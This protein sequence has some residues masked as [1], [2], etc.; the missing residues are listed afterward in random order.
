MDQAAPGRRAQIGAY[1]RQRRLRLDGRPMGPAKDRR[2]VDHLTQADV[3]ELAGVS[4]ALVAQ[5]ESGRYP[6]LNERVL[7]KLAR[8]MRLGPDQESYLRSLLSEPTTPRQLSLATV[9]P[10]ACSVINAA[11]PVSA[12]ISDSGPECGAFHVPRSGDATPVGRLGR[13]RAESRC[14]AADAARHLPATGGGIRRADRA[15]MHQ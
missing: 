6:N 7:G 10:A 12:F 4:E 5:I 2:H 14:C 9:T 3:A 1:L 8:A 13:E 11:M 15:I